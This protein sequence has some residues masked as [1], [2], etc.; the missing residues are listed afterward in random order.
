MHILG[1]ILAVFFAFV[2]AGLRKD[3][4]DKTGVDMMSDRQWTRMKARA[5]AK[6]ED[7]GVLLT[8]G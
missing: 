5:R 6:G 3:F 1:F 8:D 7:P 2:L 4:K